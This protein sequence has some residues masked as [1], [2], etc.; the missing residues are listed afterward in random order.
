VWARPG[1]IF[2]YDLDADDRPKLEAESR[3]RREALGVLELNAGSRVLE[4]KARLR[5]MVLTKKRA[6]ATAARLPLIDAKIPGEPILLDSVTLPVQ[7][8]SAAMAN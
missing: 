8:N 3:F 5:G 6:A 2:I 7:P 1:Q 4:S